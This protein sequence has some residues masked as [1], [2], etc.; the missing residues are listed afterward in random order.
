MVG[1]LRDDDH[2]LGDFQSNWVPILSRNTIR[3]TPSFCRINRFVSITFSYRDTGSKVGL[4]FTKMYNLTDFKH[5][6]SIFSLI[7]IQLTP[8]FTDFKSV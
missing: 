7:S 8:F 3:L 4:I 5:S 6:V 1:R 2:Y